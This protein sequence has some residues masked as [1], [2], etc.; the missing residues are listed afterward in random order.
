MSLLTKWALVFF[1]LAFGAALFGY[2]NVAVSEPV[3]SSSRLGFFL[4]L[5]S[6]HRVDRVEPDVVSLRGAPHGRRSVHGNAG[7][8]PAR[9]GA[10]HQ[11]GRSAFSPRR[12]SR[13]RASASS[14]TILRSRGVSSRP[15]SAREQQ[16][17]VGRRH[18][19]R[20]NALR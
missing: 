4:L 2:G 5:G 10:G 8:A 1:A 17:R 11:A 6:R 15:S 19:L 13:S 18:R 7:E 20:A 3:T 9:W 14:R 12:V 16:R